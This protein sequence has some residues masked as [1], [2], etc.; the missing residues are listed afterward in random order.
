MKHV[1]FRSIVILLAGVAVTPLWGS[2]MVMED[3]SFDPAR[4]GTVDLSTVIGGAGCYVDG[5][6]NC[7]MHDFSCHAACAGK[8]PGDACAADGYAQQSPTYKKPRPDIG[9]K[10]S[11]VDITPAKLCGYI[12]ACGPQ[13]VTSVHG[14]ACPFSTVAD[15]EVEK[16]PAGESCD[17]G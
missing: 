10:K 6:E 15:Y 2:G 8:Q 3:A 7:P 17:A 14:V 11:I 16:E 13:C 5:V 4:I 1:N 12:H 9:G